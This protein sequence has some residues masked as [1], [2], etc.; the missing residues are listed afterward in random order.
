MAEK[1]WIF[2]LGKAGDRSATILLPLAYFKRHT[3]KAFLIR[4]EPSV[5]SVF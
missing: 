4:L 3:L 5:H 2:P 1:T